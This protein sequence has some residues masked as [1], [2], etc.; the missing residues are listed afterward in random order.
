MRRWGGF[1]KAEAD[2]TAYLA[3][4]PN[5]TDTYFNRGLAREAQGNTQGAAA[6]FGIVASRDPKDAAALLH[7]AQAR[8]TLKDYHGA[9]DDLTAVIALK[10]QSARLQQSRHRPSAQRRS[11]RR[12]CR[13]HPGARGRCERPHRALQS[14][15][16]AV[17]PAQ[18]SAIHRRF[19]PRLRDRG[20]LRARPA[21][22]RLCADRQPRLRPCDRGLYRR[23]RAGAE[24]V[25]RPAQPRLLLSQLR[26]LCRRLRRLGQ[27][28]AAR[29]GRHRTTWRPSSRGR[30]CTD[31]SATMA[32]PWR[33]TTRPSPPRRTRAAG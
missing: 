5:D 3:A 9:I 29:A 12:R 7:R 25:A 14:R 33:T 32:R 21:H 31:R 18:I 11:R 19:R 24:F 30:T 15:R 17:P 2:Y 28:R 4:D 27:G 22:A 26:P 8:E 13:L 16:R 10:P 20:A 6:D 1:D 23:A